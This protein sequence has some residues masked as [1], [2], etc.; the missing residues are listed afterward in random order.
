MGKDAPVISLDPPAVERRRLPRK[1]VLLGGVIADANGKNEF[2]CTIRDMNMRGAQVQVPRT[3]QLG[4]EV[5]L[6]DTRNESAHLATVAWINTDRTGL[7]FVRS[8]SL[9]VTMPPQF[10]FLG[11]LLNEAKLRQVRILIEHGLSVEDASRVVGLT[12]DCLERFGERGIFNEKVAPLLRQ[13]KRLFSK[14]R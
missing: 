7:S 10:E 5:Y 8:Y 6:V 9:E 4:G 11:R 13:A 14:Y 2:D 12:E 3:L 1:R